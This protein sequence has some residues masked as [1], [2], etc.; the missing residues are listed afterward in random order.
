MNEANSGAPPTRVSS[1][2][3]CLERLWQQGQR[4]GLRDFLATAG[5]LSLPQL[6]AVL[7]V[8]Q[9]QRWQHG[10][11]IAAEAYL[12]DYPALLGDVERALELVYGEFLL[13]QKLGEAPQP[14]EYL[15]RFPQYADRLRLQFQMSRILNDPESAGS[16][17]ASQVSRES[18]AAGP[19]EAKT[20]L[21]RPSGVRRMD[22][23][24]VRFE[25]AWQTGQRPRIEE[26]L[27]EV[28]AQARSEVLR[29]LL[30]LELDYRR[31]ASETLDSEEFR[32][33]FPE[34]AEVIRLVFAGSGRQ[35]QS[36]PTLLPSRAWG[37]SPALEGEWIGKYR[38]VERLGQGGQAEVFRAL[39]PQLPGRDVVIKWPCQPL[40][41]AAQQLLLAEGRI[42]ARLDDPGL[43]R[44][45]DVD[46][47]EGRPFVVMEYVAGRTLQQQIRDGLPA[48]RKAATLTAQ[49]AHT[50]AHV[51]GQ[52]V[53]HRDLKPANILIDTAGRPRLVDFGLALLD[54]PWDQPKRR[55]REVSG[56]FQYMA[57][58][59]ANGQTERIGPRTD[60]FGLGAVLYALLTGRPPYQGEDIQ[61]V[62]EQARNGGIT[63]PRQLNPR[64]PRAL[65]RICLKAMAAQ[66]EQRYASAG[67]LEAALQRY[68]R[69]RMV[70][71]ILAGLVLVL[72]VVI[73]L[74]RFLPGPA[75]KLSGELIV[76]VWS[77]KGDNSKRGLRVDDPL[78]GALPVRN[79]ELVHLEARLNRPA[80][81]YLLGVDAEGKVDTFYP[82]GRNDNLA[83]PPPGQKPRPVVHSPEQW[84]KGWEAM[85][86]SGLETVLLLARPTPLP[87][88]AK[89]AAVVGRLPPTPFNNP[90]EVAVRG[91]D[92]DQP[93]DAVYV[94]FNRG[95]GKTPAEIDDPLLQLMER[96]RPH[97][98]VIRAVRFAH[99]GE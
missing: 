51:H 32:Q 14:E 6:A 29:E 55:S 67:E 3:Q 39:H 36:A 33:R 63:P 45:Y 18:P 75:E 85:G 35:E 82:W 80:Y 53:C 59:Q 2:D 61:T 60:V 86:K 91:F 21:L 38:V 70:A 93:L 1:P 49:L 47:H 30:G 52:G 40:S 78:S 88:E 31:Q 44:I 72:A 83:T 46:M 65:E 17:S 48:P 27:R 37:T 15:Q 90:Q 41:Q 62:W 26:Y 28:P 74:V 64:V 12:R 69:R 8:D 19:P 5:E 94:G 66:P 20:G 23:L 43:V 58:E 71:A 24:C 25:K 57:P 79:Q 81:I 56:T 92:L 50:L 16:P 54:Q 4:P 95:F 84:D 68:L 10:E 42:L 97:F 22:A 99:Q 87:A 96:L 7:A 76:R 77:P 34:Y 73:G 13:R 11:R 89:L 98:E 9:W